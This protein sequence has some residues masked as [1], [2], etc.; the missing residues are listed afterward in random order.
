MKEYVV[1]LEPAGQNWSAYC[2]D[3]PGCVAAADTREETLQLIREALLFLYETLSE[4]GE[5]LP[6]P[7]SEAVTVAV[8][9]ARI[10]VA[11]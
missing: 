9:L 2:P 1:I 10:P 11:T 7:V 5:S 3:V 6:E 8:N 4:D